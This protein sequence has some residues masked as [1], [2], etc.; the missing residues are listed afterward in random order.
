[1][2]KTF[3]NLVHIVYVRYL[4]YQTDSSIIRWRMQRNAM[5]LIDDRLDSIYLICSALKGYLFLSQPTYFTFSGGEL[6]TYHLLI[7]FLR[8]KENF[9]SVISFL[10]LGND[11]HENFYKSSLCVWKQK[12]RVNRSNQAD[13]KRAHEIRIPFNRRV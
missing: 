4:M 12:Q 10:V 5:P 2:M 8:S 3:C 9:D 1:M 13:L 6:Y 11:S 7:L